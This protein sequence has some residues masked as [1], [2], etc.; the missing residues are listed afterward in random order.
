MGHSFLPT[1]LV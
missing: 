1:I